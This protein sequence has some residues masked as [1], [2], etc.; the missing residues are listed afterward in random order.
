MNS[1]TEEHSP[2]HHQ[3]PKVKSAGNYITLE[4]RNNNDYYGPLFIGSHYREERVLYDTA[5]SLV[6]VNDMKAK[7]AE[8][9]SNYDISESTKATP[10]YLD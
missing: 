7:N 9:I 3:H 4:V 1:A 2:S 8:I 5:S 10:I 6:A